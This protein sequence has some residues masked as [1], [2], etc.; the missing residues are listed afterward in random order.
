[1]YLQE[2]TGS[3]V[4]FYPDENIA[5]S[6]EPPVDVLESRSGASQPLRL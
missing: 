2:D 3:N 6:S 1:M 4:S 5:S